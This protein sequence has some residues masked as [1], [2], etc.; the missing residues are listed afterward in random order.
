MARE[1]FETLTE[2][3]FYILL[4]LQAECCGTDIMERIR[5]MTNS[6]V[7]VGPGTLYTLLERFQEAGMIRLTKV[8][9]RRRSYRITAAGLEALEQ[10]YRRLN[11]LAEDYRAFGQKG[12]GEHGS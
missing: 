9:G 10:E 8:E 7:C 11:Q 6:R 2:Q 5:D 12:L 1:Q 4:C 3:M